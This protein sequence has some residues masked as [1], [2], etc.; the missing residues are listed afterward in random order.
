MN[1]MGQRFQLTVEAGG[2]RLDRFLAGALPTLSRS[3]VQRLMNAGD[4]WLNAAVQTRTSYK[5]QVGD[6][7]VVRV[8]PPQSTSI[9]PEDLPLDVVYEDDAILVVNKAPGMVVHPGAG[10]PS[11]TLVNAVLAHCPDLQGIG[12]EVRPGIVHRLDKNTSGL[13]VVAKNDQAIRLLQRQFKQRTVRKRYQALLIGYL[14]QVEGI[15]DAPIGRHRRY[16]QKMAVTSSGKSARTRWQMRARYRDVKRRPYTLLNVHLLTGR[17]H[18]IRVHFAWLGYPLLG[19][20]VYGPHHSPLNAP[21]QFLHAQELTIIH[22]VC[23]EEMTFVVPLHPDLQ[24]VLADL[25]L[26]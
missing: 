21:R 17:T 25:T 9:E 3:A 12:G 13:I 6:M 19:D 8:P 5:V 2:Q 22:P 18:Q 7:I 14:Q 4:V 24:A 15:I 16:R 20:G 1:D 26:E 23:A 10:H 11:G